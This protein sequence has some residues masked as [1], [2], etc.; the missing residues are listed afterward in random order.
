MALSRGLTRL[1]AVTCGVT[2]ANV[3]LAQPLLHT[4][5]TGLGTSQSTAGLIVT[6]TQ[7]GYAAG[8]LLVVPLGDIVARRPLLTTL[9]AVDAV[10]LA[11]SAAA[12]RLGVLGALAVLVGVSSVVVQMLIPY[13]ATLARDE[14]RA[15]TIGTLMSAL[16]LGILLSRTFSGVVA[17][18][19]GWRGV[20]AVAASLMTVTALVM[21]RVLPATGRE[22]GIGFGA[23]MRAV[24]RLAASAPVLR[25]R[26]LVGAAQFAAFSCFWT[27]VTF[28]LSGPP[29]GYSQAEIGLFALVGVVGALCVLPGGRLLDRHRH[30]RWP[31]TGAGVALLLVSFGVLAFGTHG[32][33]VLVVGALLMDACSQGVH[34]TNQAVIYDLVDA[35]R[36]RV[37]TIYMT[38]YFVGGALGTTTGTAAYDR[39]GWHGACGV[40]AGFCGV[41]LLAWLAAYRHER[42]GDRTSVAEAADQRSVPPG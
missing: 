4:I 21:S 11:A 19:L 34:V 24:V 17:G 16:L 31:V 18:V 38:T 39:Y 26:A 28:L 15:A 37:T 14:E 2:I 10:A 8:L 32:L 41:A 3:Y 22:V 9:L 6:F 23:Q 12:P 1:L 30:L 35:A 13:A 27:T 29:F 33:S 7:L 25:W 36:S 42:A 20:Y 5:A 40:A